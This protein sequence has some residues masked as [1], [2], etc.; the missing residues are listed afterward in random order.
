VIGRGGFWHPPDEKM[1]PTPRRTPTTKQGQQR[2]LFP[3]R[4]SAL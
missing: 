4:I 1:W 2:L 3:L